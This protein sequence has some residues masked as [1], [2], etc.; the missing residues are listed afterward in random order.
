ML[1]PRMIALE[2]TTDPVMRQTRELRA[3][4]GQG[5]PKVTRKLRQ[6]QGW[7][8]GQP[9]PNLEPFPLNPARPQSDLWYWADLQSPEGMQRERNLRLGCE[10]RGQVAYH[11]ET[12]SKVSPPAQDRWEFGLGRGNEGVGVT[13]DGFRPESGRWVSRS[14]PLPQRGLQV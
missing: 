8:S 7:P 12:G 14:M 1:N 5:S 3:H 10:H 13:I 2:G 4:K 6:S 11:L 9:H